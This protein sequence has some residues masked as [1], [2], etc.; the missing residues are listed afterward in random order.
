[1]GEL[2]STC[3]PCTALPRPEP[4]DV[5]LELLRAVAV[6]VDPFESKGL[7]PV[8]H[9]IGS[10]VDETGRF[11]ATGG[12]VSSTCTAP[13]CPSPRCSGTSCICESKGLKPVSHSIRSRVETR[14]FQAM[15]ST[16]TSQLPTWQLQ[17][18]NFSLCRPATCTSGSQ[19]LALLSIQLTIRPLTAM[20]SSSLMSGVFA[21]PPA[22][23]L[24]TTFH[25]TRFD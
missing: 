17:L 6:Q 5:P 7:K 11:Q 16:A 8:S 18:G 12:Q 24:D 19:K 23:G 10:R 3:T 20:G 4:V 25:Q 21:W 2:D 15:Q 22:Q 9:L 1:M 13:P 14:R